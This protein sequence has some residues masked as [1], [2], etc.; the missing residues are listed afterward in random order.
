[1]IWRVSGKIENYVWTCTILRS[2]NP[3]L[4]ECKEQCSGLTAAVKMFNIDF[5]RVGQETSHTEI[6]KL[7]QPFSCYS[8]ISRSLA[9]NFLIFA[10]RF[11]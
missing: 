2:S 10:S 6:P 9:K 8:N 5:K 1:M 7:L 11:Q 3:Y 4:F